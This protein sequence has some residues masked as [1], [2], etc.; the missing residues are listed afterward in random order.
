MS[1]PAALAFISLKAEA[2][3]ALLGGVAQADIPVTDEFGSGV[4]YIELTREMTKSVETKL[5]SKADNALVSR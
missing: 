3:E 1:M 2:R 5:D 4:V